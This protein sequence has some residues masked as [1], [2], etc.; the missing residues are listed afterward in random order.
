ME[1]VWKQGG[2]TLY[3][4]ELFYLTRLGLTPLID[5]LLT[6]GRSKGITVVSGMQRPVSV[7]RYAVSQA[8]HIIAFQQEGR[9]AKTLREFGGESLYRDLTSGLRRH[10]FVW[11]HR[12]SRKTFIGKVQD[13][14]GGMK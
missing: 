9:D 3:L 8:T 10:E 5:R 4:D 13:L 6:Q 2:W 1:E 12:P 11:F 14:E 7:T